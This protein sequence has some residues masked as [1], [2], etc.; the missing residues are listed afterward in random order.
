[1]FS[2]VVGAKPTCP[3]GSRTAVNR[4]LPWHCAPGRSTAFRIAS[5]FSVCCQAG[6][7][8]VQGKRILI[9]ICEMGWVG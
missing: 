1:M 2:I 5:G 9:A 4:T 7:A 3:E 6:I 8:L